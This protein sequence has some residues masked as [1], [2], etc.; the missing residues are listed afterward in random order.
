MK[1]SDIT[2]LYDKLEN[3]E[4]I[5]VAITDMK[6]DYIYVNKHFQKRFFWLSDN[7]IGQPSAL[8]MHPDDV[9]KCEKA[10]HE[11]ILNP[12]KYIPVQIRKPKGS[13][14]RYEW[15]EWEFSLLQNDNQEPA[16]ILCLGYDITDAKYLAKKV[17]EKESLIFN[18][19]YT[20]SHDIRGPVASMKGLIELITSNNGQDMDTL[21]KYCNY[22]KESLDKLDDAI[23]RIVDMGGVDNST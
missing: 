20:Q 3:S 1:I 17:M 8:T 22:L 9:E 14:E 18:M 16:G 5:V 2:S 15:T 13:T 10:V 23:K 12:D 6:G 4:I 11:C 19:T 7:L 21:I